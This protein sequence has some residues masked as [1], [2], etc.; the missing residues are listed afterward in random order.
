MTDEAYDEDDEIRRLDFAA[1]FKLGRFALPHRS[2][3]AGLMSAGLVLAISESLLPMITARIVDDALSDSG[4]D[5]LVL[6]GSLYAGLVLFN[7]I[8]IWFFINAGGIAATGIAN[9]VRRALFD[10]LQTLSFSF[11]D[12]NP[13]G[14]LMA[15]VT[16]D[17]SRMAS[18]IPWFLLDMVWGTA[19]VLMISVMMLVIHWQLALLV[20]MTIPVLVELTRIFQKKLLLSQRGVR[21]VNS[22]IT[23]K[24]N[25]NITGVNT[26][27]ALVREA[28]NLQEFQ[29]LS[30]AMFQYAV[31]N[32][33]Q[34][35]VYLPLMLTI[36][37][38][39]VAITLWYGGINVGTQLTLGE[40]IAF[41]QYAA[42]F[43]IPIQE[44]SST[45]TQ[46]QSA[47]ASAERIQ[48]LLETVPEIRDDQ[49]G[50]LEALSGP[51]KTIEFKH[52]DFYYNPAEKVLTDFNL[53]VEAGESIALVGATGS[54]KSTLVNLL[55]RFYE[56][57]SGTI[58]IN[59]RDYRYYPLLGLQSR[60][61]MVLQSPHLFSGSILEN[62]RY[63]NLDAS[64]D[65]VRAAAR[66]VQADEFI[67]DMADGYQTVIG[68]GGSRLSS[69]Q[70]Q[71]VSLARAVLAD[72]DI[73]ILDEATSSIDTQSERLIQEGIE[74]VLRG[75]ISFIVA[76]RL[77]TIRAASRIL[78]IDKGRIVEQGDHDTLI[79]VG[80][81]YA[82]L[83]RNQFVKHEAM[84]FERKA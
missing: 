42:L 2:A 31:R 21:R 20:M 14:W 16:S 69:G 8:L 66:K 18:I 73:F 39:G 22:Q 4:G 37:S 1:W 32:K 41:M 71:L 68:E 64:D 72:P 15:R 34:A 23:A 61:G 43:Y 55:A 6:L 40:L 47:Q 65:E 84:Q 26:S 38:V 83:Y 29:R 62:I 70:K 80:G 33:L 75:R 58:L 46:F 54:G 3:L 56:P 11:Y 30:G 27:K 77:S 50:Q 5:K 53:K 82:S 76:H 25:E 74:Q 7:A 63:G 67:N 19:F 10:H 24:F 12:K 49:E 51:I 35:S 59:D 52:V 17:T 81:R 79:A 60:L 57:R 9:N 48:G 36:G 45:F 44:M 13:V 28:Q 78:V